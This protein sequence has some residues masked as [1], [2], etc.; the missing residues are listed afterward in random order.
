VVETRL[1][2]N[3]VTS[4]KLG[5]TQRLNVVV[6][7]KNTGINPPADGDQKR[8]RLAVNEALIS[9]DKASF[10][11]DVVNNCHK[12]F[13]R[14]IPI[15]KTLLDEHK[16]ALIDKRDKLDMTL[17]PDI[18][19]TK[20]RIVQERLN[21]VLPRHVYNL[22]PKNTKGE[23]STERSVL[24]G[25]DN[26]YA[27]HLLALKELVSGKILF[28]IEVDDAG[29]HRSW[30]NPFGTA[31]GRE[32]PCGWSYVYLPKV[33]R[34]IIQPKQGYAIATIDFQQQ[35][36]AILACFANDTAA[37]D[38]YTKG[39][40]YQHCIED[41]PW[42]SLSREQVKEVIISYIYGATP[43]ALLRRFNIPTS[44]TS[45]CLKYLKEIFSIQT[46]WLNNYAHDAYQSG[47]VSCLDW[48]MQVS[49]QTRITSLK[50]WPIQATGADIL[51]RSCLSLA[52]AKIPV[53]GAIHDSIIVE[54]PIT[55][56][57][58]T[59]DFVGK[60]MADASAEVLGGF[61]LKTK[62]EYEAFPAI[63]EASGAGV[64]SMEFSDD[65]Y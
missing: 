2:N 22:W 20:G 17:M 44:A 27:K 65:D 45:P 33:Y 39:D 18:V 10:R 9:P 43:H 63:A 37:M 46:K 3:G 26:P 6:A 54:V 15:F 64:S 42:A 1:L 53:V 50:N 24:V 55:N 41:G 60:I 36:P 48:H 40:L 13:D 47:S 5:C 49:P 8:L 16:M 28:E 14:G 19:D 25:L 30:P 32:K 52:A 34:S 56:Y 61:R 31:T 23:L 7:N 38:V 51:R 4:T 59:F 29:R 35:E 58:A 11:L 21:K 57:A 62:V 12:R